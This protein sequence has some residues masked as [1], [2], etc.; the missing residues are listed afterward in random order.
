MA[1]YDK[2]TNQLLIEQV[3]SY[4]AIYD[5]NDK[6]HRNYYHKYKCW[7]NIS[8]EVRLSVSECKK[9]WKCLRDQ[10]N[11]KIKEAGGI[12]AARM[13]STWEYMNLMAF[14]SD[15]PESS[16]VDFENEIK[17]ENIRTVPENSDNADDPLLGPSTS[18]KRK[19]R[20]LHKTPDKRKFQIV[21]LPESQENSTKNQSQDEA[22]SA[23][24]MFFDSMGKVVETF[25]SRE[26]AIIRAK[27]CQLV[28]DTEIKLLSRVSST[29]HKFSDSDSFN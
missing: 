12:T 28:S 5:K 3:Q 7:E 20:K 27:V 18:K 26:Q 15:E 11:K 17:V 1:K 10:Y 16:M 24:K 8:A 25:P 29:A 2:E 4:P 19:L 13:N 9:K 22:Q 23:T 21:N 14:L 6:E